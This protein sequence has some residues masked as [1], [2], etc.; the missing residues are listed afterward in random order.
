MFFIVYLIKCKPEIS[1]I[2]SNE[3]L[4]FI[5]IYAITLYVK[6]VEVDVN[7]MKRWRFYLILI[8]SMILVGCAFLYQ[9]LTY[10]YIMSVDTM[11]NSETID[12]I[13][14]KTKK[15]INDIE[16]YLNNK[17]C[18]SFDEDSYLLVQP[19][20][21][22]YEGTLSSN[23]YS[24]EFIKPNKSKAEMI[25][26]NEP[27]ELIVYNDY[28]YD[29]KY[30]YMTYLPILD[31]EN[32]QYYMHDEEGREMTKATMRLYEANGSRNIF[33]MNEY[34]ILYR[35]RGNS[36]LMNDK[37]SYKV[38]LI[39]KNGNG[40]KAQLLGMR[41]DDDWVLSAMSL[42]TSYLRDKLS[43][44]IWNT[45]N[46]NLSL[47]M[48]YVEVVK[49][50]QY[51]GL[52]GLM[53]PL[54]KKTFDAEDE[55]ILV[56]VNDWHTD[57]YVPDEGDTYKTINFY[58]GDEKLVIDEYELKG[59]TLDRYTECIHIHDELRT[60]ADEGNSSY[61]QYDW[62]SS[63]RLQLFYNLINGVD[64][65]YKNARILLKPLDYGYLMLSGAWDF[66][67]T[68]A[69]DVDPTA[70]YMDSFIPDPYLESENFKND[71]IILFKEI[72]DSIYNQEQMMHLID[73][74]DQYLKESGALARELNTWDGKLIRWD[75]QNHDDS[76][77][78]LKDIISTRIQ[79]LNQY[80]S[81]EGE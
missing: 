60:L 10:E 72:S 68:F 4:V 14:S 20:H 62:D 41:D 18:V 30:I 46:P 6:I 63:I 11:N 5:S 65:T 36:A 73:S 50:G 21:D 69:W 61:F 7:K 49:D 34:T 57:L 80:Y 77:K 37:R 22:K 45:V 59:C 67:Y 44:D 75:L 64:N 79:Y 70:I 38:E 78:L 52:Y 17:V 81:L 3:L 31:I 47:D 12:L 23:K 25:A 71:S 24:I 28:I 53:E 1:T 19:N 51:I 55:D 27:L 58:E 32:S 56:K 42:D 35:Y 26:S 13:S 29:I 74:Y 33:E 43:R 39:D 8:S 16:L 54:D 66:D 40:E 2:Y 15:D 76:I 48:E 9:H